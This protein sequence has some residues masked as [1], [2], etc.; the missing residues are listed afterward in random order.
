M[1]ETDSIKVKTVVLIGK[2][3][4]ISLIEKKCHFPFNRLLSLHEK[5]P[6]RWFEKFVSGN[7]SM[8]AGSAT[9]E[10]RF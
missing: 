8:W 3:R 1:F 9:D 4:S 6:T 7:E 10:M 5:E 2:K